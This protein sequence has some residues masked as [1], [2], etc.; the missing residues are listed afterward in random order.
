V[1]EGGRHYFGDVLYANRL[2]LASDQPV[3][4]H[5][6]RHI[7][8]RQHFSAGTF[9]INNAVAAHHAGDRFLGDGEQTAEAAAFVRARQ[10]GKFDSVE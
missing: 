6:A 5:Q 4:V 2:F 8:R 3:K 10:F 1:G 7:G 9:V